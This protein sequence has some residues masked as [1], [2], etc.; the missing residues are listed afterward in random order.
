M[1]MSI[2]KKKLVVILLIMVA[3]VFSCSL[4]LAED[5]PADNMD[6]VR[7]KIQADKKLLIAENMELTEAEAK[8]FWPVY[9]KY[10]SELFLLRSRSIK[11]IKD[12]AAAYG[13]MTDKDAKKFLNEYLTIE[14]LRLKV[15]QTYLPK[16]RKVLPEKKVARYY[17]I[18]NKIL[19]LVNYELAKDIPLVDVSK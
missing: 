5:K 7:A 10:Q 13:T 1:N 17:Q 6:I 8:A 19:A 18:E 12:Y 4:C 2:G 9:E 11:L 14:G 15:R 16:F 3:L